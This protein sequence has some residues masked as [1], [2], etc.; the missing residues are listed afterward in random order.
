MAESAILLMFGVGRISR[1]DRRCARG[2]A[3]RAGSDGGGAIASRGAIVR[4][5][6][7]AL[8]VGVAIW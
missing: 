2:H 8:G 5:L 4:L 3:R 1:S 6:Q 7:A